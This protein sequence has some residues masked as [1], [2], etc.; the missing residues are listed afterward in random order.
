MEY[1]I[2]FKGLIEKIPIIHQDKQGRPRAGFSLTIG[3]NNILP[4]SRKIIDYIN[5][6]RSCWVFTYNEI[7][8]IQKELTLYRKIEGLGKLIERTKDPLKTDYCI[9]LKNYHLINN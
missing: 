7:E 4:P 1:Q 3:Y 6:N 8:K 5:N 2:H 9:Y